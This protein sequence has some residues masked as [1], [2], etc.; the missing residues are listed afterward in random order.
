MNDLI[1]IVPTPDPL[2]VASGWF[3]FLL[4][5][6]YY[7]HLLGVGIMFGTAV[8]MA[9]GYVKGK[10][11]PKWK[12]FGDR[13][14][15]ILPFTIA[16]AVN[17]GVAPLL[18]LQVLYGNFFYTASILVG[19]PWLFVVLFLIIAYYSAYWLVFKKARPTGGSYSQVKKK[20]LLA[21]IISVILAWVAFMLVNVNTL[22][23]APAKW[24]TYFA[25]KSG[26][27]LNLAETTLFPRYVFYLFLFIAIG[28]AFIAL[29][30]K[31]KN[32]MAESGIGFNFGSILSGNFAVLTAAAFALY[33]L[34][35]PGEIK[36]IFLGGNILWTIL[37]L[38]FVLGL[39]FIAYLDFKRKTIL[40]TLLLVL[41]LVVFVFVR[42]HIRHLYLNPFEEKFS[43]VSQNTQYGVM[44]LFFIVLAAGL[45][46]IAWLLIKVAK[47]KQESPA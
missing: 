35:L 14:A 21:V 33:L 40:S 39:I 24:K 2:P 44:A 30:Y 46:L 3:F 17:L 12:P 42:Q 11:D 34:T 31:I 23:M 16:F 5:L 26:F 27:N 20:T 41:D 9:L 22:M 4:H 1:N 10:N 37:T 38:V 18:F 6:T 28:G 29:F 15:K 7:L 19:I 47:E 13:M 8:S 32:K 43:V 25:N 36:G 45:G